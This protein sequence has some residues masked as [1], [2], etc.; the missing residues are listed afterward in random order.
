MENSGLMLILVIIGSIVLGAVIGL[1][2]GNILYADPDKP[3]NFSKKGKIIILLCVVASIVLFVSAYFAK[4]NTTPQDEYID[5]Y[6]YSDE[7]V[8]W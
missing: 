8:A 2:I 6:T 1:V 7:M 4:P 5:D 3:S